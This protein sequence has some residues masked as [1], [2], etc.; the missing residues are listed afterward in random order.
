M[1]KP[2]LILH[3]PVSR[4]KY[5]PRAITLAEK[6]ERFD[7]GQNNTVSMIMAEVFEK[8][9]YFNLLF[10]KV[11]DWSGMILEFEGVRYQAH[12][13]KT[14]IFYALQ[15][16]HDKH[17]CY[18]EAR[19]REMHRVQIGEIKMEEIDEIIYSDDDMNMLIDYYKIV[20]TKVDV[21]QNEY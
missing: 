7:S 9:E 16:A 8:W 15:L 18:M 10:W 1:E 12:S 6:F 17:I 4:S 2:L 3:F 20:K 5:Y 14:R 11:V 19:I 21:E 13:D